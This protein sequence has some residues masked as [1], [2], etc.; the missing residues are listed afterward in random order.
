MRFDSVKEL[1]GEAFRRLRVFK[2]AHLMRWPHCFL[3][4][5]QA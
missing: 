5:T 4:Q 1:K 2:E 3:R